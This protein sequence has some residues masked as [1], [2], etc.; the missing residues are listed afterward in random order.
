M[1]FGG[2]NTY[3]YDENWSHELLATRT[4]TYINSQRFGTSTTNNTPYYALG[5]YKTTTDVGNAQLNYLFDVIKESITCR[6]D[7]G[8]TYQGTNQGAFTESNGSP[9][10]MAS[11]TSNTTTELYSG[12][13]FRKTWNAD[14][15]TIRSTV[16]Y[17]YGYQLTSSG[18]PI[19]QT[20]LQT[21]QSAAPTTFTTAIGPRQNKHYIQ[22]NN[23]YLDRKT[24]LKFITSYSGKLYKNVQN[25]TV[26]FKVE[27][28]F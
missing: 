4:Y 13:G 17:E 14:Q 5:S 19:T 7:A 21:T 27:Y 22:F 10:L 26:M 16:V 28:R 9:N 24:G 25:H 23:S 3:K 18:T 6:L 12:I 2:Y 1:L 15:T 20:I 8:F 11:A